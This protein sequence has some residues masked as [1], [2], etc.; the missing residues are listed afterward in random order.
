MNRLSSTSAVTVAARSTPPRVGTTHTYVLNGAQLRDILVD[1]RWV[2]FQVAGV[3]SV[4][5]K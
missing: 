4:Q 2:T 3:A 1:G 5:P